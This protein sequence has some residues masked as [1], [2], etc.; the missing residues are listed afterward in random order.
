MVQNSLF[1]Q[2][3]R[4]HY[5]L[6][7][8]AEKHLLF[9]VKTITVHRGSVLQWPNE[10]TKKIYFVESGFV[11][12]FHLQDGTE[13]T[14]GF[15]STGQFCTVLDSFFSQQKSIYGLVCDTDCQLYALS[16]HDFMAICEDIMEFLLLAN[17]L[18][19]HYLVYINKELQLY[20]NATALDRYRQLCLYHPGINTQIKHKHL[21][22]YL[23]IT[24]QSFTRLLKLHLNS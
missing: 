18:L 11:R 3:L 10:T 5:Q 7:E 6:S 19:T 14:V 17:Q 22:S 20:R 2:Y 16:Y 23:G 8:N 9:R 24:P 13:N 21:S 15:S 1:I 12:T 4:N